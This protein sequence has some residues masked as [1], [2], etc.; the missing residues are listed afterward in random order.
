MNKPVALTILLGFIVLNAGCAVEPSIIP[1]PQQISVESGTFS[2]DSST[3]FHLPSESPG[4]KS[5]AEYFARII[6]KVDRKKKLRF[7]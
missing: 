1:L 4:I 2:I 7:R 6:K 5:A 3:R